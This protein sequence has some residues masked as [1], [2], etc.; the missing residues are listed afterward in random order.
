M[1][2]QIYFIELRFRVKNLEVKYYKNHV[3]RNKI[4]IK[5]MIF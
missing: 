3:S 5:D 1:Y 4:K 2:K